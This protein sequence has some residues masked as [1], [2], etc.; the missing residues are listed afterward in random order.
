ME[1]TLGQKVKDTI[2]GMEGIAVC[3]TEWMNGCVR[4]G[5]QVQQLKD[6][7]P[8]DVQYVD[9]PQLAVVEDTPAEEAKPAHGP[10][11]DPVRQP[12]PTMTT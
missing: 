5:V 12:D 11:P 8:V 1:I 9:E 6:G 7:V 3:R 10:R 4:I 2:T